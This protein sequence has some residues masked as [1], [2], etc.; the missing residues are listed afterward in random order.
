MR[1]RRRSSWIWGAVGISLI[2]HVL[3][4]LLWPATRRLPSSKPVRL[5]VALHE[6]PPERPE[7]PP[8][9]GAPSP[10]GAVAPAEWT[11]LRPPTPHAGR[12]PAPSKAG[13]AG[14]IAEVDEQAAPPSIRPTASPQ[15]GAPH[16]Q[17][18]P[19]LFPRDILA[20]H[21]QVGDLPFRGLSD[22][23]RIAL[24][25]RRWVEDG[26]ARDRVRAGLV[27]PYFARLARRFRGTF[28]PAW[29]D[30]DPA[31]ADGSVVS[32]LARWG[33]D[34]LAT[35]ER[36]G[37]TGNPY[38]DGDQPS[39]IGDRLPQPYTGGDPT[40][41]QLENMHTVWRDWAAGRIGGVELDALVRVVQ[42]QDGTLL[43]V[44]IVRSSGKPSY[45]EVALAAVKR[46]LDSPLRPE[47]AGTG[48]GLEGEEIVSLWKFRTRFTVVP[49]A[50]ALPAPGGGFAV[51]GMIGVDE[52]GTVKYPLETVITPH[53][54][55]V[56]VF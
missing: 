42:A 50:T 10:E 3:L 15:P 23:E 22:E 45:D 38:H 46:A 1:R 33:K 21:G 44:R 35:A 53:V 47:R 52:N 31:F 9:P 7:A 56:A 27:D 37:K 32:A 24:R 40:L 6:A 2:L 26:K 48:L 43:D 12:G 13:G 17:E 30:L 11:R 20:R 36:Y 39:G 55:L 19:N 51:T 34:W 16:S 54:E 41:A 28:E 14:A 25:V 49:P 8:D 29:K 5:E 18:T 4:L